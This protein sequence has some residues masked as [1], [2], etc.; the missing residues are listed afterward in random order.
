MTIM[1]NI[2]FSFQIGGRY[3]SC[4]IHK[5]NILNLFELRRKHEFKFLI[6]NQL[7]QNDLFFD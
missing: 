5:A 6:H 1:D 3:L 7:V 4:A 2:F